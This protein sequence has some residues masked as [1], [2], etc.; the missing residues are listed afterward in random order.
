M[1]AFMLKNLTPSRAWTPA[2]LAA[3]F[4]ISACAPAPLE[5]TNAPVAVTPKS[6]QASVRL[7]NTQYQE[8]RTF[9]IVNG[10]RQEVADANCTLDSDVFSAQ[11]NTPARIAMP[12]VISP[13]PS[14]LTITCLRNGA[15]GQRSYPAVLVLSSEVTETRPGVTDAADF[16]AGTSTFVAGSYVYNGVLM[17]HQPKMSESFL[18][19]SAQ[20]AVENFEIDMN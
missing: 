18:S 12:N 14:N 8:L 5:I 7:F 3:L 17:V 6:H 11:A 16:R 15:R 2:I 19:Q 1:G 10:R 9:E 4:L 20:I 13:Q